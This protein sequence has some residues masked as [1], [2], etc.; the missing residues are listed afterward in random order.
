MTLPIVLPTG[1]TLSRAP[2]PRASPG[3]GT[4]RRGPRARPA[5]A[6]E[7]QGRPAAAGGSARELVEVVAARRRCGLVA[8]RVAWRRRSTGV[9]QRLRTENVLGWLTS[10]R[11]PA[12]RVWESGLH[13]LSRDPSSSESLTRAS[14]VK[15]WA[16]SRRGAS[17]GEVLIKR[18]LRVFPGHPNSTPPIG[19]MRCSSGGKRLAHPKVPGLYGG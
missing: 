19:E 8:S 18:R 9:E 17:H 10:E 5:A 1:R 6:V 15:E 4:P 11:R 7:Q 12:G 16:S 14:R 3:R 13:A 2:A